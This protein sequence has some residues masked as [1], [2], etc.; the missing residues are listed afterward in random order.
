MPRPKIGVYWAASCGGCDCSLLEV[1]E[2][3]LDVAAAADVVLWPCATDTKYDDLRAMRDQEM[4]LV[5]FNGAIRTAENREKARI[6]RDKTRALAAFGSCAHTGGVIGLA[7]L[8]S[9]EELFAT[10]YGTED[11]WP[12]VDAES[13]GHELKLPAFL[14]RLTPLSEVVEVDYFVPGCPPP[15]EIVSKLFS[16]LL[17]GELPAP[18]AVFASEKNLCEECSR[19]REHERITHIVRPHE[20]EPDPSKCL[21]DQGY[22]CMGPATR[23]GCNAVCPAANMPCTGC[24]GPT[25]NIEDQGA[26]MLNTLASLIGTGEEGED[27]LAAEDEIL[28]QVKDLVGTFYRFS[29]ACSVVGRNYRERT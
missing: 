27:E 20:A 25:A 12:Q 16:A 19:E 21:L 24:A 2:Q 1:N 7:N 22:I 29:S 13:D 6:I 8:A 23:G 18:G 17:Y 9:R 4:D 15:R 14:Q 26:A 28:S 3:I 11:Q 10:V 5:L